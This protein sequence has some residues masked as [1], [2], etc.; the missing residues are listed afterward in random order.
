ME[1]DALKGTKRPGSNQFNSNNIRDERNEL[2][3][4][5]RKLVQAVFLFFQKNMGPNTEQNVFLLNIWVNF[6]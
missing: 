5:N 4:E 6:F 1:I 3:E 2:A